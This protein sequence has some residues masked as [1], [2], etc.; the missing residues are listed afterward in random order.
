MIVDD[1]DGNDNINDRNGG[2]KSYNPTKAT[3]MIMNITHTQ[4]LCCI[5]SH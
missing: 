5:F 4:N 1:D 2:K 3:T